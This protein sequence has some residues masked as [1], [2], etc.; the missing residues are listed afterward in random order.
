MSKESTD[1]YMPIIYAHLGLMTDKNIQFNIELDETED[2]DKAIR[3]WK[4]FDL[5]DSRPPPM[6]IEIF[7]STEELAAN[8]C[9]VVLDED[10]NRWDVKEALASPH[11][12]R[13]GKRRELVKDEVILERWTVQLGDH[14]GPLPT[15]LAVVLPLVYK[16]SIV[17]FRSLF[18]YSNFLP[19]RKFFRGIGK[20]RS[21][22]PLKLKY[23]I[24]DGTQVPSLSRSDNLSVNLCQSNDQV[25]TTYDFGITES[26]AGPFS[27]GVSYR[28]DCDFRVEDSE[29]LL[30]SRF[31][32]ADDE[33]FKP[34]VPREG[35]SDHRATR[36]THEIGSLPSQSRQ[37]VQIPDL[38]QAYGSLS[39]F[40]QVGVA[41]GT[42]PMSALR[43]AH[44]MGVE[45]P[46]EPS[47]ERLPLVPRSTQGSRP[48]LRAG[49]SSGTGRRTSISFQ[50]FK[51]RSLSASPAMPSPLGSSPRTSVARAPVLASLNEA[52]GI[53]P[54]GAMLGSAQKITGKLPEQIV[55]SS[56]SSSPKPAP[57]TRYSSSFSHR[58]GRLSS[59]G[60][61]KT[62]EDQTSSG[63]ASNT[64]STAQPGS[65]LLAEGGNGSSGSFHG[66]DENISDFLKM[67]DLKKDLLAPA[68]AVAAEA[69]TR[70]T[71]AALHRFHRMRD[72]NRELSDS[73]SSSLM[74]RAG[75]SSGGSSRHLA[76]VPP[77]VPA[78]SFST[79]SSPGKPISP[80]TPHTPAIPSRLSAA[81]NIDYGH[82]DAG[83]QHHGISQEEHGSLSEETP[84]EDTAMD[85]STVNVNAIPIPLSPRPYIPGYRRS[86]SVA[87][88]R[89]SPDID[90]LDIYG[91]RPASMGAGDRQPRP[92]TAGPL[93]QEATI[94]GETAVE[95]GGNP[96]DGQQERPAISPRGSSLGHKTAAANVT[97]TEG[98]GSESTSGTSYPH[99]MYR[100]RLSRGGRG[101]GTPPQGSKSSFGAGAGD[102]GS[103]SSDRRGRGASFS[104]PESKYE[105]DEPF[106]FA[107]SDIGTSRRS[108]EEFQAKPSDRA[109]EADSSKRGGRRGGGSGGGGYGAWS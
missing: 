11:S 68:D 56:T 82:Q 81:S 60:T 75:G 17:L 16:K 100:S 9:L 42:S 40:H 5:K 50:P 69:S 29:A 8:Q 21:H 14:P 57:V 13:T 55:T 12:S 83:I 28:L 31:L 24:V 2:Y 1:G 88:R 70:R 49:D 43:N 94:S 44:E 91:M 32:G 66:D 104:R 52:R 41:A 15:D 18:T 80:H 26:P 107:M 10:G 45:S 23:R 22:G 58:R 27:I 93:Q 48:V 53:P 102:S 71:S 59:G 72:T 47:P 84:S 109:A 38:T 96:V 19:A 61:T 65:S 64:S 36:A 90:E 67:L 92:R 25:V 33:L 73:M 20:A 108:L 77:M 98:A 79:S 54:P 74:L 101:R 46:N 97:A 63:K 99:Q 105:E 103:T 78:T 30:S 85:P 4:T 76:S 86:S 87:Q 95:A 39:T 51:A 6:I 35:S 89:A 106:L 7:L 34:S 62:D 37:H 3:R